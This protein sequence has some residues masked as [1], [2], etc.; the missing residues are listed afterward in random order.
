M[1][2]CL[3]TNTNVPAVVHEKVDREV[4]H[5]REERITREVHHHDVYHR[6]LPIIDIEVLPA[7]HY[8]RNDDGTL[9]EIIE[10]EIPGT[11]QYNQNWFVGETLSKIP[12][13]GMAPG[14]R[15][16]TAKQFAG[17]EGDYRE[18]TSD[19]GVPTT[20]TTWVHP[21]TI[22][23]TT[24]LNGKTTPFYFDSPDPRD[25]GFRGPVKHTPNLYWRQDQGPPTAM[26]E[27]L[28]LEGASTGRANGA[29][30]GRANGNISTPRR[31]AEREAFGHH[32]KS[33]I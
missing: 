22:A 26:L 9:R 13:G 20:E 15:R 7:R 23:T 6:I 24:Y 21:P 19:T 25:D 8:V 28:S 4:H 32:D 16:F 17:T 18:Y 10:D 33:F 1:S 14:P 27:N 31:T 11:S 29:T 30:G 3:V 5:I 2:Y 12:T